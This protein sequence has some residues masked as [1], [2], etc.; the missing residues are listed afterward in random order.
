M[1][2][3]SACL[4]LRIIANY[5]PKSCI[6]TMLYVIIEIIPLPPPNQQ[7][8]VIASKVFVFSIAQKYRK[9]ILITLY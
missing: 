1:L 4:S 8:S 5:F 9:H 7:F 6:I 3:T 2:A